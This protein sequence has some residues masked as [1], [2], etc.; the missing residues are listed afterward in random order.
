MTILDSVQ[1]AAAAETLEARL[2]SEGDEKVRDQILLALDNVWQSQGRKFT[3][4][5]IE[6]WIDRTADKLASRA[7][8]WIDEA[9]LPPLAFAQGG[10][11]LDLRTMR[12]M[13]Y[14]QSRAPG[15]RPDVECKPLYR[16]I[17]RKTSGDFAL[18]LLRMYLGRKQISGGRWAMAIAGILGDDRMVPV[19]VQQIR[20]WVA[21]NHVVLR[22]GATEALAVLGSDTALCSVDA[23][24]LKY[25]TKKKVAKAATEA[26]TLAADSLGIT[27]DELGDRIVPWLDFEAGKPRFIEHKEKPIEVRIGL[28]FK[29]AFRDVIKGKKIASLPA[30][31]PAEV[32]SQYK[33]LAVTLREVAKGQIP[34]IENLMV[35]QFRWTTDRWKLLFLAHPVLLPFAVRLVWGIYNNRGQLVATF[36]ALEDGT[37]TNE[38]DECLELRGDESADTIGVVHPLDLKAAQRFAWHAHLSDYKIVAPFVQLE[39]PIV[40]PRDTERTVRISTHYSNI[41]VNGVSFRGR[42]DRLGWQRGPV[43]DGGMVVYYRKHY[44]GCGIDAIIELNGMPILGMDASTTITL[45]RLYFGKVGAFRADGSAYD[46]PRDDKDP[47]LLS[48]SEVPPIVFSESF[49]DLAKVAGKNDME[50]DD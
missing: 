31:L 43:G 25:R 48:F 45:G 37:L 21:G 40:S 26:L 28:D 17:D 42:L 8:P 33:D 35:R 14:R 36:R 47:R 30:T 7:A 24:A 22:R 11:K 9:K 49:G 50:S 39:R 46:V 38:H 27:V 16:L 13:L 34:R 44:L 1:T 41:D 15:M 4:K 10:Q 2:D 18:A 19:L 20:T 32:K 12:Y 23:I 3:Q 6:Q 5:Q 29:L